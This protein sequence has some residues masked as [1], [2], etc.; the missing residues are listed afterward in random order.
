MGGA[1]ADVFTYT[2]QVEGSVT[3]DRPYD[4]LVVTTGRAYE[5]Y[6]YYHLV[7][8]AKNTGEKDCEYV[9]IVVAFYDAEGQVIGV[10]YTYTELDVVPAGKTSPFDLSVDSLPEF[11]HYELWV[12]G[13]PV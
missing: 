12:E 9:K 4:G 10:D 6:G 2:L 8:E 3:D 5:E 13:S 7:G 1:A 11:D